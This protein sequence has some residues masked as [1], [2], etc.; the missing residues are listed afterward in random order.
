M[1]VKSLQTKTVLVSRCRTWLIISSKNSSV[2][3]G[4]KYLY[5]DKILQ[6]HTPLLTTRNRWHWRRFPVES[7]RR[8][9]AVAEPNAIAIPH[10]CTNSTTNT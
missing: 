9:A 8:T 3:A 4:S 5:A 1:V 10:S 2:K 7:K 6:T